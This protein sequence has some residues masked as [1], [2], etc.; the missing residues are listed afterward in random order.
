MKQ[1]KAEEMARVLGNNKRWH[2]HG[3]CIGVDTLQKD[4][5]LKMEDYSHNE[6]LRK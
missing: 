3:R 6:S 1:E 5:K 4:V 2:S